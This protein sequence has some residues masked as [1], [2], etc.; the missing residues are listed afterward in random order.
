MSPGRRN[1]HTDMPPARMTLSSDLRLRLSSAPMLPTMTANASRIS[2]KAGSRS[3]AI[4]S[5]MP[6]DRSVARRDSRS[7]SIMSI[8][9]M[10]TAQ[11]AK[12]PTIASRN[13]RAT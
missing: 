13:R 11:T 3:S 10:S 4:H 7:S 2:V 9:K 6:I 12:A 1:C 5:S 8:M